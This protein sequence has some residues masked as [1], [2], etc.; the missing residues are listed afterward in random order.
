MDEAEYCQRI[1]IMSDGRIE[2]LDTPANLKKQY[3]AKDINEVFV[4]IARNN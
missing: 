4:K 2:A 1:S 3:D